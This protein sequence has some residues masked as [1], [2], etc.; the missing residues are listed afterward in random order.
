M[1]EPADDI[2]QGDGFERS[3]EGVIESLF[4]A[5]MMF[6]NECFEF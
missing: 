6:T 2:L 5:G 3:G 1:A 4:G